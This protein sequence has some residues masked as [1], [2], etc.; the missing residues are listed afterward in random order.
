MKKILFYAMASLVLVHGLSAQTLNFTSQT[1]VVT[2]PFVVSNGCLV[3]FCQTGS[4]EGGKLSFGFTVTNAGEF[5]IDAMVCAPNT[6]A[7]SFY[8]N[9]DA[10][11]EDPGMIWDIPVT[12][13]FESRVV[14]W[15]GNGSP[16]KDRFTPKLFSLA[17]GP[18]KLVLGGR[19]AGAQLRSLSFIQ[20]PAA[21]T[22]L[23]VV[24]P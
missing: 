5:A 6:N 4:T 1:A 23:H 8:I 24:G 16:D 15:R 19:E 18:H 2:A 21:P 12:T 10:Q 3:Q 22:G 17:A 14:S 11:P 13:G 9:I 20:R 7:N